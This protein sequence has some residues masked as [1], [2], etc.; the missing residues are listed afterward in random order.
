MR[1][2]PYLGWDDKPRHEAEEA[3]QPP[4]RGRGRPSCERSG[5]HESRP[6]SLRRRAHLRKTVIE[7]EEAIVMSN[8]ESKHEAE[9]LSEEELRA[10]TTEPLPD[11]E[12]MSTLVVAPSP[13][14]IPPPGFF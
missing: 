4:Y 10:Q 2:K 1:L 8:E 9:P 11:R 14:I 12:V 5:R 3:A 6:G 7:N 13:G